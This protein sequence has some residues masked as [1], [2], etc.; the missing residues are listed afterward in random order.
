MNW[1]NGCTLEKVH[2][3]SCTNFG[4]KGFNDLL[5]LNTTNVRHV[6]T[7]QTHLLASF[8]IYMQVVLIIQ[9]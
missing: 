8:H 5:Q 4:G 3:F 6:D 7:P 1:G 9:I 2:T